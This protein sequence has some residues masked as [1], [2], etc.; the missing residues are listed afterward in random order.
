MVAGAIG[1]GRGVDVVQSGDDLNLILH[2]GERFHCWRK[3]KCLA[4]A[5]RP[6]L[7]EIHTVGNRDKRHPLRQ[8][9]ADCLAALPL[10]TTSAARAHRGNSDGNA[11]NATHAPTPRRKSRGSSSDAAPMAMSPVE[12]FVAM[13][14]ISI[15]SA[16]PIAEP[17]RS[18]CRAVRAPLLSGTAPTR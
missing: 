12:G 2:A 5:L 10:V 1:A 18:A 14:G 13:A 3:L 9:A 11:G 15:C 17:Y 8:V 6:P 7:F 16:D 4:F